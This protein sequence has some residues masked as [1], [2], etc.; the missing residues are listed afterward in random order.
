MYAILGI[1]V[2]VECQRAVSQ[3]TTD[4]QF[5]GAAQTVHIIITPGAR[6]GGKVNLR[7]SV[8]TPRKHSLGVPR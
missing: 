7:L 3:S 1:R 6:P 8:E 4:D 2:L 5:S